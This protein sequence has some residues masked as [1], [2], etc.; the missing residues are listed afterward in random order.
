LG[1]SCHHGAALEGFQRQTFAERPS[2]GF[3]G[4]VMLSKNTID[5]AEG[6]HRE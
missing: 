4:N 1:V 2:A 6:I 3:G 5:C